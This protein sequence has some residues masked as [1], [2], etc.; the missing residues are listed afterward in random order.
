MVELPISVV[1]LVEKSNGYI[2][3]IT[4]C[5]HFV[6]IGTLFS[7]T[8]GHYGVFICKFVLVTWI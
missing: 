2:I 7:D 8:C 1:L 5:I 6:E 4:D 3:C